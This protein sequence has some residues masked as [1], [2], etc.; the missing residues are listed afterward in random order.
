MGGS[1]TSMA[2]RPDRGP[3]SASLHDHRSETPMNV[4]DV[5]DSIQAFVDATN[6]GDSEAF[7][8]AFTT[9]ATLVDWGRTFTG[10]D[11]VRAWD[12]TDNI[13]VET[14]F[15]LLEVVPGDARDSYV[16]TVRVRGNGYNG[17]G[18]MLFCLREG[19]IADLRIGE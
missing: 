18:P 11:G 15:D 19:L 12:R 7:V 6:A 17:T 1:S 13:G 8:A 10:H 14:H 9:D 3:L 4:E 16:A 2:A 5:P